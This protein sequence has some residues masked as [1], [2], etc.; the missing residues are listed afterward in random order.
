MDSEEAQA[1]RYREFEAAIQK[2]N[3]LVK[4]RTLGA[5]IE[6]V[7]K[8]TDKLHRLDIFQNLDVLLDTSGDPLAQRGALDVI[9]SVEEKSRF[10]I[11]TGTEIG[12]DAGSANISLNIRNVFGGAETL[13][14]YMSAG[15]QTSHVFE[16]I[17]GNPDSKID[18]TAFSLT[19]NNQIYSSHDEILRG[20]ALR[21]RGISRL[22][23]HELSYGS[24]WRQICNV[25][26][27]ASLR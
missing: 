17:N 8:A 19:R 3:D 20:V 18:I 12:N 13:E 2:L 6:E 9:L 24:T 26:Q 14:A 11:K 23:F 27:D 21:W 1:K 4:T 25:A 5:I 7:G 10:W 16:P 15:T 22:G